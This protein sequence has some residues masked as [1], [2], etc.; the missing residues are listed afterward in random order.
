MTDKKNLSEKEEIAKLK[1]EL[2]ASK[3]ALQSAAKNGVVSVP[4]LG[5]YEANWRDDI[6][7]KTISKKL[8][9]KDG[10]KYIRTKEGHKV[11]SEAILK[12]ANGES[13]TLEDV[14]NNEVLTEINQETAAELLTYYAKI[15]AG[16]FK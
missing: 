15:G 10:M 12:I 5:S 7:G 13:P 1:A 11:L 16:Y 6:T 14:K 3:K 9:I 4:I 8:E 2:A